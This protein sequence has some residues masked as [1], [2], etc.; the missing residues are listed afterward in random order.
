MFAAN[1][2]LAWGHFLKTPLI[3][4]LSPG[5]MTEWINDYVG[6]PVN[7]N[8]DVGFF[9]ESVPPLTF[10]ERL[11]NLYQTKW[12]AYRVNRLIS[13]QN[14]IVEKYFGPGYPDVLEMQKDLAL[15]LANYNSVISGIRTFAPSVKSIAGIH[16]VESTEDPLPKVKKTH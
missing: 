3:A 14:E 5:L 4:V 13:E 10:W 12:I 7:I 15:I 2:H 11:N 1:C 8:T 6:N 16:V 9:S